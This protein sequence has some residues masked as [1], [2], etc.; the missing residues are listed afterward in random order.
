MAVETQVDV[1]KRQQL[2]RKFYRHVIRCP[3]CEWWFKT[4]NTCDKGGELLRDFYLGV[5]RAD[6]AADAD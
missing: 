6:E 5:E 2:L 4:G 1:Q 3:V